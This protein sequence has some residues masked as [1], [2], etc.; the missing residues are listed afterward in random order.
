MLEIDAYVFAVGAG[1]ATFFSPCGFPMLPAYVSYYL[2][3]EE[4]IGY[5]RGLIAGIA[6]TLGY[7]GVFLQLGIVVYLF[8]EILTPHIPKMEVIVGTVL[9]LLGVLTISGRKPSTT[10]SYPVPELNGISGFFIFGVLYAAA[11]VSCVL[12]VFVGLITY[13]MTL[14]GMKAVATVFFIYGSSM[15]GLMMAIALAIA[16]GKEVYIDVLRRHTGNIEKMSAF[17]MVV[18]GIYLV[19]LYAT[20]L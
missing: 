6:T 12:P 7:V 17:I 18:V 13:A 3:T 9:I 20:V 4:G 16:G 19:Y 8:G 10:I 2:R 14:G 1:L 11:A 15:G 5:G